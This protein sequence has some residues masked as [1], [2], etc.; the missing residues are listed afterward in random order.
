MNQ[1]KPQPH[2]ESLSKIT[3]TDLNDK[4]KVTDEE[5]NHDE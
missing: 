3:G 5:V 1:Q 2:S 4:R